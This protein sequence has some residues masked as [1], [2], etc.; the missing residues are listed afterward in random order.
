MSLEESF[1]SYKPIQDYVAI[2][3]LPAE[4]VSRGGII[5]PDSAAEHDR[6]YEGI[7]VAIGPG[8]FDGKG[9]R[10]PAPDLK[11]GDHVCFG[12]YAG[13]ESAVMS[14]EFWL[15]RW[16]LIDAVIDP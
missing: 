4:K 8:R 14:D 12:K 3:R 6:P 7:V 1:D 16:E 11:R 9:V 13:A 2:K 15:V 5:I 10:G